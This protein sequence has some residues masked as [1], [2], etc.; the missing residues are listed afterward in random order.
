MKRG[1]PLFITFL[2]GWILIV[3]FFIPHYPFNVLRENFSITFDIVAAI[4][5]ILGGGNLVRARGDRIYLRKSGWGY[6]IVALAVFFVALLVGLLRL[7]GGDAGFP[8]PSL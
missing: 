6:G 1:V 3:A 4:A 5:F 2:M 7:K 8:A